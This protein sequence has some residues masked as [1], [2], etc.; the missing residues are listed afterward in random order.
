MS[1]RPNIIWITLDSVRADHT[2]MSGYRR[3]TTPNLQRIS[4]S[5]SGV[6]FKNC[7]SHSSST[8]PSSGAIL[9]GKP[10]S[11]NTVGIYGER[12]PDQLTTIP[13]YLRDAGYRTACLSRNSYVSSATGLNRGFDKFKWISSSTIYR[14]GF[15]TLLGYFLNL[16]KH[17]AGF[18]LDTAKH[19]SPYLMNSVAGRWLSS[20]SK[21]DEPFFLYLHY[22]EPHRPYYPPLPYIDKYAPEIKMR[23]D[24]AAEFCVDVH[25]R[26]NEIVANG[27][28]LS[29]DELEAIKAMYDAEIAY[30][31]EMIGRLFDHVQ[32]IGFDETVFIVTAD[33]GE[34]LGE[35]GLLS[36]G[37]ALHDE[38]IHVPLVIHGLDDLEAKEN[39]IVQ[40]SDVMKTLL[41]YGDIKSGEIDGVNLHKE[42]REY[43][44]S[45]REPQDFEHLYKHNPDFDA[46]RFHKPLLTAVRTEDY[47]YLSS[48]W[49]SEL[50]ELPNEN[51]DVSDKRPDKLE[52]L[53][54]K[55]KQWMDKWDEP[56]GG[57]VEGEFSGAMKKQLSDLGYL[58]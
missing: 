14:T 36:H 56:I 22:N 45:Q 35:Y 47:K 46:S 6:A 49:R 13:E 18:S 38:V 19:S 8:H 34:Y 10:P 3:D 42:S 25:Y 20:F 1:N 57:G 30:T 37:T 28:N 50:F 15:S 5:V 43:A 48:D 12:V 9:T 31:D 24:K 40:H 27:C 26:L 4:D 29:E 16:R 39:D 21:Y 51:Q 7:F 53:E 41:E 52:D 44:V 23:A 11:Y 33:H 58:E 32:S 17:S 2:S 55:R 54:F